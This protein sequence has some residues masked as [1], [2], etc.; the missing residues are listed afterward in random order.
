MKLLFCK[1][2]KKS[3][4]RQTKSSGVSRSV[5]STTPH[6]LVFSWHSLKLGFPA[7]QLWSWDLI[8]ESCLSITVEMW[9]STVPSS[10]SDALHSHGDMCNGRDLV[11]GHCQQMP[12]CWLW[13]GWTFHI[14]SLNLCKRIWASFMAAWHKDTVWNCRSW[15]FTGFF[16]S[17]QC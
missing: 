7:N 9:P 14:D 10:F 1:V 13:T 3:L 5:S 17:V 8:I 4:I 12:S 6:G 16:V 2:C 11:F 15:I